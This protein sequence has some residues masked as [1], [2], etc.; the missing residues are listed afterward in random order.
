MEPE[1]RIC[2]LL[3]STTEIVCDLGLKDNLVGITHECDYPAEIHGVEVVTK[4]LIDHTGNTSGQINTHISEALHKGSGIY[5]IDNEALNRVNPN[6]VL[7]Q[8]LCEVC[9]VSYSLVEE[10]VRTL[11]G[12]Q[13]ILSFEPSNLEGILDSILQI[14][15]Q[16]NTESTAH[17]IIDQAR[18][19]LDFVKSQTLK[20]TEAPRVLGLEWLDP[21]FI[22][23]HWVPEMIEI[24]GGT[25]ALGK[26]EEPS[27]QVSWEEVWKSSPE[28][29]VLMVCGFD[30]SKTIEE[31]YLLSESEFW[32]TFEGAIYAVNGSAYFSRPGP[33]II[34]GVEILGEILNPDIFGRKKGPN[35]WKKI[36]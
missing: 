9:A 8:E 16:T 33:R 1:I 31:F 23:G 26:K 32:K 7:T 10:S 17:S 2:S 15:K 6:I 18:S 3:P 24:A 29:I 19:R 12:D 13:K 5:A 20:S 35:A 30:L 21:P 34:D 36:N 25:P 27:K 22:G 14:G 11:S 4:S 28:I